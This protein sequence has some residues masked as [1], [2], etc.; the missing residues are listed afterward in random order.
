MR[1]AESRH[2]DGGQ[3]TR[4]ARNREAIGDV[5]CRGNKQVDSNRKPP[6]PS[7]VAQMPPMAK[8]FLQLQGIGHYPDRWLVPRFLLLA[9]AQTLYTQMSKDPAPQ[10]QTS[11]GGTFP[12]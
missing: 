2:C 3:Q 6:H 1:P 4:A 10:A 12:I 8:G 5:P 7:F 9:L 11:P